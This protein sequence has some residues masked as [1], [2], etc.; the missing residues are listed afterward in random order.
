MKFDV[1]NSS[2]FLVWFNRWCNYAK[3]G[4]YAVKGKINAMEKMYLIGEISRKVK[5]SQKRIREYEKE[6]FIAPI[7]DSKT[8]NRHYTNLDIKQIKQVNN[9]IHKH[10]LT[11]SC[12]KTLLKFAPCWNI[13]DCKRT[14]DCAAFKNP[15]TPCYVTMKN[16][17]DSRCKTCPV[18]LNRNQKPIKILVK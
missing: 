2:E 3:I 12:L 11:I 4:F 18:F 9:L 6:G 15:H 14:R 17:P 8:N 7:R 5:L 13:F 16:A 1:E 10:G